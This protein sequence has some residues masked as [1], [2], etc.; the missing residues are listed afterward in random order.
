MRTSEYDRTLHYLFGLRTFGIHLGLEISQE[1]AEKVGNPQNQYP[2]IH[3]AGTNGKGSICALIESVLR[4]KGLKTGL[5]TSPHLLEFNERIRVN[6][7]PISDETI[8]K[9]AEF[10]K[11]SVESK[12]ASFFEVTTIIALKYF[13]DMNVD[14][15]IVETGLGARLDTTLLVNP[16]ITGI[17]SISVDH[18]KY[19]GDTIEKIAKEKAFIMRKGIP[20]VVSMNT[21]A[22]MDVFVQ[23]SEESGTELIKASDICSVSNINFKNDRLTLDAKIDDNLIKDISVPLMGTHQIEN[24]KTALTMLHRVPDITASKQEI[25]YGF[26]NVSARGRMEI[27]SKD[28]LVIYDV[29][30]NPNAVENLFNSLNKH[31]PT[32]N[33]VTLLALL[34]E[35]D[36][37]EIIKGL[38]GKCTKLIC[39]EIP[40]HDSISAANLSE[41]GK[42]HGIDSVIIPE[43]ENGIQIGLEAVDSDSLF[44]IFGSHYFA[45]NVYNE[46][47]LSLHK[48][49]TTE[50]KALT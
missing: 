39:S 5:Y 46:F 41:E 19:L 4:K 22:V 40:G 24:V 50:I 12:G 25:R 34:K 21:D 10:L 16:S 47:N 1:L 45:E 26:K 2:A 20:C 30:H 38:F 44:I 6:G 49:D 15:A 13:A 23:H 37:K 9:Y 48:R 3:L 18:S 33:I 36:Y 27:V 42:K 8:I 7:V 17:T 43:L 14:I 29:A 32:K 11:E 28:P 35:K 31:F